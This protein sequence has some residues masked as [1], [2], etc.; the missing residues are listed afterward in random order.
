MIEGGVAT[1]FN[2]LSGRDTVSWC[3]VPL[4]DIAT[5]ASTAD[6]ERS[7]PSLAGLTESAI[8]ERTSWDDPIHGSPRVSRSGLDFRRRQ[9]LT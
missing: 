8:G 9:Q 4:P 2:T 6:Q 1:Y 3:G 7:P 5:H